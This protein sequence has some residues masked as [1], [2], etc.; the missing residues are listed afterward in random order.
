MKIDEILPSQLGG[1]GR[2]FVLTTS[3]SLTFPGPTR[4]Y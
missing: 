2:N 3:V 4:I 1:V